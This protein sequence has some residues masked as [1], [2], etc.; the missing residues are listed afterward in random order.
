[1]SHNNSLQ[2]AVLTELNWEPSVIAAH[3]GVAAN[4]G[5][6][7]LTGH[8]TS[9][10]EKHAAEAAVHRVKGVRA[11]AEELEVRLAS[12]AKRSDGEIASA[13]LHALEWDVSVP[14][15]S[16]GVT[17]ERGL[18]TLNGEVDWF[19]EKQAA[20]QDLRRLVGVLGVSNQIKLKSVSSSDVSEDIM[21]ALS[22]SWFFDPQ[23]IKVKA[24]GGKIWLNGTVRSPH[25]REIAAAAAWAAPGTTDVENEL[26]IEEPQ[27]AYRPIP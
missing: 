17:V 25:E 8:V 12:D 10:A 14:R 5:V 3:I 18:V 1:M 7:T 4:D 11:V 13:A 15:D 21:D 23:S 6:V 16:V 24:K 26:T 27:L 9:L 20:E 22:R 19:Y 2:Q